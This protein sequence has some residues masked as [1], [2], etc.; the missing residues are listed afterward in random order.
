MARTVTVRVY[1]KAV[2][3]LAD[4]PNDPINEV[5]DGLA[6]EVR[7]LALQNAR[8][9][10]PQLPEDFLTVTTGKDT[11]GIFFRVEPDG[12]GSGRWSSYLTWKE[13]REHAWLQP[14]IAAVIG[15]GGLRTASGRAARNFPRGAGF[16]I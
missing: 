5:L 11:K 1:Q 14:A 7:K 10:L 4:D 15:A 6:E 3:E 13:F 2:E 8:K 16:T 12:S 9:I